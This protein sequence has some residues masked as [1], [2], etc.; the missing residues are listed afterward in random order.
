MALAAATNGQTTINGGRQIRGVWDASGAASSKPARTGAG[1]PAACEV[2]EQ[3]FRTDAAPGQN[4]HLCTAPNTW[5]A[6]S[7]SG[8]G[9]STAS[10]LADFTVTRASATQL[11]VNAAGTVRFGNHVCAAPPVPATL[12]ITPGAAVSGTARLYMRPD[13]RLVWGVDFTDNGSLQCNGN[14]VAETGGEFPADSVPLYE[15]TAADDTWSAAGTDRRAFMSAKASKAAPSG[16]IVI[17]QDAGGADVFSVDSAAVI[18]T[19]EASVTPAA[20]KLPRAGSSGEIDAAWVPPLR[21]DTGAGGAAGLA[22]APAAGDAAAG[23]YLKADG[24]W[25]VPPGGATGDSVSVN[26]SAVADANF[27]DALPAAPAG[28]DQGINVRW[29]KDSSTPNNVSAYVPVSG[30]L[31]PQPSMRRWVL[32]LPTGHAAGTASVIGDQISANG[33][34]TGVS[35]DGVNGQ[36]IKY[37]TTAAAGQVAGAYGMSVLRLGYS[38][39]LSANVFV[40]QLTNE[41]VCIGL[42]NCINDDILSGQ[43]AWFRYSTPAGDTRWICLSKDS[44]GTSSADTGVAVSTTTVQRLE[45]VQ[46]DSS[47]P[48]TVTFR[49]NGTQVCRFDSSTGHVGT[50][51]NV[52]ASVRIWPQ[53]DEAKD[54]YIHSLVAS[55]DR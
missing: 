4:L 28:A 21:G 50:G 42:G 9:A 3:Y 31:L 41:R 14:C 30:Y 1:L 43:G 37:T 2:G 34:Q 47:N 6:I 22:P 15:W 53:A 19:G 23:K 5:T 52:P 33:T 44:T 49:I 20:G 54:I 11:T 27:S 25:A 8:A 16:G 39:Y 35:P 17:A 40:G 32:W 38:P 12:S 46:D 10:Q 24:T 18:T 13:C 48:R 36:L 45:I 7:G 55:A 29:Q 26:A 51:Q